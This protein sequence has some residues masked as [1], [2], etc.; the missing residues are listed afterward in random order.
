MVRPT[1]K[2]KQ[3]LHNEDLAFLLEAH[4]GLSARIVEEAGFDGVWASSLAI[5]ASMGVRDNNEL[6]WTQVVNIVELMSDATTIPILVDADTGYGDFNNF[7]RLVKKV[8]QRGIAAVCIEDKVFPKTNSFLGDGS[9]HQL[10]PVEDFCAKLRAARDVLHDEDFSVVARVEAFIA[11]ESLGVALERASA[12]HDAGADAILIHS[13]QSTADEVI[14]FADEWGQRCP[15]V[16]VP[17][18]YYRTPVEAFE[19]A[20]ISMVIWANHMVRAAI[21]SMQATAL[22]IAR[23]RSIAG[24]EDKIAPLNEVFRLQNADELRQAEKRYYT[25]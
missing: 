14:R 6:S 22:K 15:L 24:I 12:Y 9:R 11:G 5:S 2:F 4:N 8:E 17:T 19:Q 7:R 16:V 18:T 10:I 1:T 25:S 20:G 21:A 23:D 13:K 3:L